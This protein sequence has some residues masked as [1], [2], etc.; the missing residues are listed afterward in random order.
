MSRVEYPDR[1]NNTPLLGAAS[2]MGFVNSSNVD[3][4]ALVIGRVGTHG[5]VQRVLR[6]SWASDNTLVLHSKHREFVYQILK[7]IDYR[8]LNRGSTQPLITQRDIRSIPMASVDIDTIHYF[9]DISRP[10]M[11]KIDENQKYNECLASVRDSL[12]PKLMSGEISVDS[13]EIG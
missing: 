7:R 3:F 8:S 4:G 1:D 11:H 12:L 10:L 5:V 6:P 13:I 2:P 9:E